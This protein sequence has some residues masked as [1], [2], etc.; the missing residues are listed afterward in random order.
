MHSRGDDVTRPRAASSTNWWWEQPLTQTTNH[1]TKF[2]CSEVIA[3]IKSEVDDICLQIINFEDLSAQPPPP[4]AIPVP[5]PA[6]NRLV[7]R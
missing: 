1:S 4:P 5:S 2:L 6:N 7:T 3:P